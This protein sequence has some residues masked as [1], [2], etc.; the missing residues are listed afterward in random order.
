MQTRRVGGSA[1]TDANAETVCP[2]ICSPSLN[3]TTV[4]AVGT[5]AIADTN[6]LRFTS[7]GSDGC[8]RVLLVASGDVVVMFILNRVRSIVRLVL[9][10]R[11]ISFIG[12]FD[13]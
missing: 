11:P 1:V 6:S 5:A 8:I 10:V 12:L 4:T 3:A 13:A 7:T 2:Q 9:R